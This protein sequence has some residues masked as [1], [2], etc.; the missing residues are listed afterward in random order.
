[1]AELIPDDKVPAYRA[2]AVERALLGAGWF[3]S[4]LDN[5]SVDGHLI[6]RFVRDGCSLLVVQERIHGT[7]RIFG[8]LDRSAFQK[9]ARKVE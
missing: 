9:A 1:M 2:E 4:P 6:S 5:V 7:C 3:R 8:V